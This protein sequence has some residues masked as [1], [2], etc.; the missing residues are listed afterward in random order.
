MATI[1]RT[2]TNNGKWPKWIYVGK[3]IKLAPGEAITLNVSRD[4]D[5]LLAAKVAMGSLH[6]VSISGLPSPIGVNGAAPLNPNPK[7]PKDAPTPPSGPQEGTNPSNPRNPQV[8]IL[9]EAE[10]VENAPAEAKLPPDVAAEEAAK[11]APS[12]E[13]A[14]KVEEVEEAAI[15]KVEEAAEEGVKEVKEAAK[16]KRKSTRRHRTG[17]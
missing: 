6:D 2:I 5:R 13:T 14:E 9:S 8:G 16:P 1:Q 11:G 7:P 10:K 15:E 3:W 4:I 12:E 17:K